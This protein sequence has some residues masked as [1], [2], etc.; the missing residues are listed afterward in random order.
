MKRCTKWLI[1]WFTRW[2]GKF[3]WKQ[4]VRFA[5]SGL[6]CI[7][8]TIMVFVCV[9]TVP[10]TPSDYE[11]LETQVKVIQQNPE[12]LVETNCNI[13]INDEIITIE[14]ENDECKVIAK[15]DKDFEV[16]STSKEDKS[17]FWLLTLGL[18]LF[19]CSLLVRGVWEIL[20]PV[21]DGSEEDF[22]KR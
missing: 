9:D 22:Q 21:R 10:A 5:I 20:T 8:L 14:F 2:I 17:T 13:N 15:Y 6:L 3:D 16:L 4:I 11:Q 19:M 7:A 12:L 1:D 18:D